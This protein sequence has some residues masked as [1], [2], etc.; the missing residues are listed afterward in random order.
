MN[1]IKSVCIQ[2]LL[3]AKIASSG[4]IYLCVCAVR[5]RA[6]I[7]FLLLFFIISSSSSEMSV[8]TCFPSQF[9]QKILLCYIHFA[10]SKT[11]YLLIKAIRLMYFGL[12]N[13]CIYLYATLCRWNYFH[14]EL[15]SI[16]HNR[17]STSS[18][19]CKRIMFQSLEQITFVV[20]T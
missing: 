19:Q 11:N 4:W 14:F 10:I 18:M 7:R 2:F 17:H 8:E 6:F 1:Q 9:I 20:I 5:A 16:W 13:I 15:N 12:H 3:I